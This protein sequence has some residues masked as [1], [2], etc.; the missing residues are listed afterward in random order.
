MSS[1][2]RIDD[3]ASHNAHREHALSQIHPF[4]HLA[5]LNVSP[6]SGGKP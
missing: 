1:I 2:M 5:S 6:V 3:V 4:T